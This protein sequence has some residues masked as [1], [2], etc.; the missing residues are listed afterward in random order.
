MTL[1][2]YRWD[3]RLYSV[4]V[5]VDRVDKNISTSGVEAAKSDAKDTDVFSTTTLARHMCGDVLTIWTYKQLRSMVIS[6]LGRF[7]SVS[8]LLNIAVNNEDSTK[9]KT[10]RLIP[11]PSYSTP[12]SYP[13]PENFIVDG[14]T[15]HLSVRPAYPTLLVL[16]KRDQI[17][18]A[19][20]FFTDSVSL[21][22]R[23]ETYLIDFVENRSGGDVMTELGLLPHCKYMLCVVNSEN[24]LD[25]SYVPFAILAANP[26][27][28][29]ASLVML[30]YNF[31]RL[32]PHLETIRATQ[33]AGK[34]LSQNTTQELVMYFKSAPI[35]CQPS[36]QTLFQ[37]YGL[38][39]YIP[40]ITP[41]NKYLVRRLQRMRKSASDDLV[42]LETSFR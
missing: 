24:K 1:D 25:Q 11:N 16:N 12:G 5:G 9:K 40:P 14:S 42:S 35:Y 30:P 18:H 20:D 33:L 13:I 17:E 8:L 37:Q 41:Y 31:P 22:V 29:T 2:S 27:T 21:K 7:S 4:L 10:F 6:L 26:N 19:M 36:L 39:N 15:E 32:I 3:H 34:T 38:Q 23:R 28:Y